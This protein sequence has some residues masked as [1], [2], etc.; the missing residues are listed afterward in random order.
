MAVGFTVSRKETQ[1]ATEFTRRD[2][3]HSPILFT[4]SKDNNNDAL[5]LLFIFITILFAFCR[6]TEPFN[7]LLRIYALRE[8]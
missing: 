8:N 2:V 4:F 7:L 6:K 3:N 5:Q 1:I